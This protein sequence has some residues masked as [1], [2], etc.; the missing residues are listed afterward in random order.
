MIETYTIFKLSHYCYLKEV[1]P[2]YA[3]ILEEEISHTGIGQEVITIKVRFNSDLDETFCSWA[4]LMRDCNILTDR[5]AEQRVDDDA[6][7]WNAAHVEQLEIDLATRIATGV[8]P[9][10][11]D[12]FVYMSGPDSPVLGWDLY[13]EEFNPADF[14][15]YDEYKKF[16]EEYK[17]WKELDPALPDIQNWLSEQY[18]RLLATVDRRS[19]LNI[20]LTQLADL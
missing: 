18:Q 3:T 5:E 19:M 9:T 11:F 14:A 1:L 2:N 15:N 12:K 16:K 13:V 4:L 7:D 20:M 8:W 6:Y 10:T 17:T